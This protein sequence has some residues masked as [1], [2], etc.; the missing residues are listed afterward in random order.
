[1]DRRRFSAGLAGALSSLIAPSTASAA[2][3]EEGAVTHSNTENA[4]PSA[5]P[6]SKIRKKPVYNMVIYPGMILQDLV[7]PMTAF[8][9]TMGDIR[10]VSRDLNPV[11]TDIGIPVSATTTYEDCPRDGDVLFVPGGLSGTT[12]LMN[13]SPTLSFLREMSQHVTYV[14][15][16]CTGSLLLGAAGLLKGR[17]ATSHWYVHDILEILGAIPIHARV[18]EDGPVITGGG[19]TAG[20]D[21]GLTIAARLKGESWARKMMLTLEY[22]PEPPFQGGAPETARAED[23]AAVLNRRKARITTARE[24]AERAAEHL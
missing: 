11:Q 16:V 14:T 2:N 3:T 18:I 19:V 9:L 4:E 15:S 6:S 10:L 13:D 22:A 5:M 20:L 1:M 21:F 12:A 23:V 7:G 24:A 8:K 17:R